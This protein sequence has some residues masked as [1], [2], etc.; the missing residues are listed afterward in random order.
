MHMLHPTPI[1]L[2]AGAV[3]AMLEHEVMHV[4]TYL[5]AHWRKKR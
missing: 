2:G 4:S 1:L 5:S 3:A